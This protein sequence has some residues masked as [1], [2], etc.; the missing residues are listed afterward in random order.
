M[1]SGIIRICRRNE[2]LSDYE[3]FM[4][5]KEKELRINIPYFDGIWNKEYLYEYLIY[6]CMDGI[7]EY[8]EGFFCQYL[9]DKMLCKLL[10]D[11]L[12]DDYY[13]GS[14]VQIGAACVLRKMDKSVLVEYKDSILLAQKN[15]VEWKRPFKEPLD[16]IY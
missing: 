16:W 8:I 2:M 9:Y 10:L 11:F 5:D 4:Q 14:D 12:L 3:R 13:D 1:S 7:G 6:F 15:E